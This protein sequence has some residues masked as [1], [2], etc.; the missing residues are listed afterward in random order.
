MNKVSIDG[1]REH[2]LAT[3]KRLEAVESRLSDAANESASTLI[4]HAEA[5]RQSG[6]VAA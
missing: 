5:R 6:S 1:I 2:L 4:A 3:S